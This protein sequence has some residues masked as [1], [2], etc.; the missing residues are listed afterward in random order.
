[1]TEAK[2]AWEDGTKRVVA[3]CG[4]PVTLEREPRS[5]TKEGT[6]GF[7]IAEQF[8]DI[9]YTDLETGLSWIDM[10]CVDCCR[11]ANN[12]HLADQRRYLERLLMWFAARPEC[13]E[14]PEVEGLV[15]MLGG[16]Y[17]RTSDA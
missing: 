2:A 8:S 3:L 5:S 9:E 17:K 1:M 4:E 7:L 13:I 11:V 14:D 12:R 6:N 10:D 16:L 15:S